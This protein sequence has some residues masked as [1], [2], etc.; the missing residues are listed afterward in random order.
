M[1]LPWDRHHCPTE[2]NVELVTDSNLSPGRSPFSPRVSARR[3]SES[4][5]EGRG[6]LQHT[7]RQDH[8][9]ESSTWRPGQKLGERSSSRR[10]VLK[11]AYCSSLDWCMF[12]CND[13]IKMSF[14][15]KLGAGLFQRASLRAIFWG[16]V[17]NRSSLSWITDTGILSHPLQ[18]RYVILTD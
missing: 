13:S 8:E 12:S 10:D 3:N 7:A 14:S 11:I 18:L 6:G 5:P 2:I 16:F 9:S 1:P 4:L 17:C 15:W